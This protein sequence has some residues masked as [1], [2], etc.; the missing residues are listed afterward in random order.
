MARPRNDAVL[1]ARTTTAACFT[2]LLTGI[3]GPSPPHAVGDHLSSGELRAVNYAGATASALYEDMIAGPPVGTLDME[4]IPARGVTGASYVSSQT[5]G[6]SPLWPGKNITFKL[7]GYAKADFIRD[8]DAID[9][10]DIFDPVAIFTDG[11]EGRNTRLH[12]RQTR[13]NLDARWPTNIGDVRMFVEGDFFGSGETFRLRHAYGTLGPWLFGQTWTT[14]THIEALPSTLDFESPAAF[15]V[16]RRGMIRWSHDVGD[17]LSVA[18]AVEDT[19]E[20]ITPAEEI[21]LVL[22]TGDQRTTAPDFVAR[23]RFTNDFSQLQFAGIVRT[24]GFQPDGGKIVSR[25]GYG[26]N[27]SGFITLRDKHKVMCQVGFGEG[28]GGLRGVPDAVPTPAGGLDVLDVFAGTIGYEI[29]WAD[30]WRSTA[31]FSHGRLKNSPLQE[32][33]ALRAVDYLAVNLFWNFAERAHC[34][35]EYLYGERE[36][37]GGDRGTANRLQMSVWYNLP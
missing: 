2:M 34:G 19:R 32:P 30:R 9:N 4:E 1:L 10:T 17:C 11:R 33:D 16:T 26:L 37:F 3:L 12:A 15:V 24:L 5:S 13:L 23:T 7:G 8:F 31:V 28:V 14:F 22:F 18:I 25:T 20:T 27:W 35:I 6:G 29:R 36:D 21:P